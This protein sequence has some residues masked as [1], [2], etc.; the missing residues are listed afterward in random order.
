MPGRTAWTW[1]ST[2]PP[3]RRSGRRPRRHQRRWYPRTDP[4]DELLEVL[5]ECEAVRDATVASDV[6]GAARLWAYRET[7]TEAIN[8]AGVPVKLDVSVPLREL[9]GLVADLPATVAAVAPGGRPIIFGHLGEGNLHGNVLAAGAAAEEVT[10]AVLRQGRAGPGGH[11][12][13]RSPADRLITGSR[14]R[15]A[16]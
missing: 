12:E 8:A 5:G 6:T 3:V 1:T 7:H 15:T 14:R 13:P 16:A 11:V 9:P 10:D 4:T 2:W